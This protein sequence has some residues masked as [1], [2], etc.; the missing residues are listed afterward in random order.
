M[1]VE[2]YDEH[3]QSERVRKWLREYVPA[4]VMGLVLAFGGIFG[5]RYWQD[6]QAGQQALA[7]DYFSLIQNEI[8]AGRLQIAEDHFESMR[9]D[10]RRSG[11][12][13]LAGLAMAGAY[14]DDGRLEP[15]AR[16][17][18]ELLEQRQM[19]MLRPVARIRLARVLFAQGDVRDAL[20][21][22]DGEPPRGFEAA[23]HE[24]RGDLLMELGERDQ[25]RMAYQEALDQSSQQG[26]FQRLLQMK[27]DA[28]GLGG[29]AS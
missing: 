8:E 11:Y 3:E 24:L 27:I 28:T 18:R 4:I 29:E 16:L 1:A 22:I 14:V 17:Y 7:A 2:L 23:W 9:A 13:G 21:V 6:Q 12:L 15:A 25:A 26:G 20:Q 5:F 10:V 19:E